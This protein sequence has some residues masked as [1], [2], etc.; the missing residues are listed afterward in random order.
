MDLSGSGGPASAGVQRASM[1]YYPLSHHAPRSAAVGRADHTA[2]SFFQ[3]WKLNNMN[4]NSRCA[5]C[6]V[7]LFVLLFSM[8]SKETLALQMSIYFGD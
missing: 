8:E 6:F 5:Q 2:S 7:V 1:D 4:T 3:V